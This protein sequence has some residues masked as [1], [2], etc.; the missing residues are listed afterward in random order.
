MSRKYRKKNKV[1]KT[2]GILMA[3]VLVIGVTV[4][5]TLALM[6]KSTDTEKNTFVGNSG[7]DLELE[8]PEW[9]KPGGGE[10]MAKNYTPGMKIPKDPILINKT[11][12]STAE[13]DANEY[14]NNSEYVAIKL[15]YQILKANVGNTNVN[16]EKDD[17]WETVSYSE[18]INLADIVYDSNTGFNTTNWEAKAKTTDM[19]ENTIF[20][21]KQILPPDIT[22]V[23]GYDTD[24]SHKTTELFDHVAI[25]ANLKADT[26]LNCPVTT[27]TDHFKGT[28]DANNYTDWTDLKKALE[29]ATGYT[30]TSSPAD[31][32]SYAKNGTT[33]YVHVGLIPFRINVKGY[34]I[35]AYENGTAIT[36]Y[37]TK[38]DNLIVHDDPD[39]NP[40]P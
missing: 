25:K 2:F 11:K 17:S 16:L 34:A 35:Q 30:I 9:K 4:A 15:E 39:Y 37:K 14:K 7:L 27:A 18:F 23:I 3:F 12:S 10:D 5:V 19:D 32:Y 22:G 21:Y 13:K 8:E 1:L 6:N 33:V 28:F 40:G 38:L 36:D 20:Y 31:T 29:D 26:I 24:I